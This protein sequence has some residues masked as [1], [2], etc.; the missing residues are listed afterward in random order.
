MVDYLDERSSGLKPE[1]PKALN[2]AERC[3][4]TYSEKRAASRR[5]DNTD[6]DVELLHKVRSSIHTYTLSAKQ[7]CKRYTSDKY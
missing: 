7:Y 4:R 1:P 2:W 3:L 6:K 5:A